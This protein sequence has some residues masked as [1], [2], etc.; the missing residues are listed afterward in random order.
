MT[1]RAFPTLTIAAFLASVFWVSDADA[2]R[3]RS[4]TRSRA[5]GRLQIVAT[6]PDYGDFVKVIGGDRV[7]VETIVQGRQDPHHVRPKPSFHRVLSKADVLIATGLDLE[8]WLP[9]VIDRAGNKNIRSGEKGFVAVSHNMELVDKPD[10]PNQIMGD[11]HVEGNPHF[12]CS[13]LCMRKVAENITTGLTKNDPANKPFYE[14]NLKTL[15]A[16]IDDRLF[17]EELVKLLGGEV[18]GRLARQNK[19][20]DFLEKNKL[21]GTPL[22]DKLG[23]WMKELLPLRGKQI[24]VYHK[25]WSYFVDLFGI[26]VP[27]TIEPKPGIPPSAKDIVTLTDRMRDADIRIVFAA[28]YFDQKRARSVG[29]K[30]GAEVVIVPLFVNGSSEARDYF[31]L[32][33]IWVNGLTNAAKKKGMI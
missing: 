7:D 6:L 21:G 1:R 28:N 24:V 30:V 33:D 11:V 29:K 31:S 19:L 27:A 18:L 25:N 12:T 20:I 22:I 2:A 16:K 17:G 15:Q 32:V 4:R 3:E 26:Q 5:R 14:A 8:M 9:T 10:N 23:G 13:P